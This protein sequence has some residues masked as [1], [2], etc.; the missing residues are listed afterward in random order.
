MFSPKKQLLSISLLILSSNL[1]AVDVSISRIKYIIGKEVYTWNTG[2]PV[3][4]SRIEGDTEPAYLG[5]FFPWEPGDIV[6]TNDLEIEIIRTQQRITD[7]NLFYSVKVSIVPPRRFPNKRTILI[8]VTDGFRLR[9]GG[10]NAYGMFGIKNLGGDGH[11]FM[12]TAG[13]NIVEFRYRDETLSSTNFYWGLDSVYNY[14][15]NNAGLQGYLGYRLTPDLRFSLGCGVDYIDSELIYPSLSPVFIYNTIFQLS[16][17][18]LLRVGIK[19]GLG[20]NLINSTFSYK[21][22]VY[23]KGKVDLIENFLLAIRI[24]G[25]LLDKDPSDRVFDL[26]SDTN[27]S[28]RSGYLKEELTPLEYILGNG[29]LRYSFPL[30]SPSP[31]LNIRTSLFIY[32]DVGFVT[33]VL[34]DAYGIGG[35]IYFD[36]P[37]FTGFTFSYGWNRDGHGRFLFC[38]TMGF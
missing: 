19:G 37:V 12:A 6:K 35:R 30:I 36:N 5:T 3:P 2:D 29:E 13:F 9:F 32:S 26:Y 1:F 23:F 18:R 33:R 15:D 4:K 14:L 27:R 34:K 28:I 11:S 25:G 31:I 24:G 22:E 17:N 10:G 38:G 8:Q 20:I 7:S 21:R 16:G